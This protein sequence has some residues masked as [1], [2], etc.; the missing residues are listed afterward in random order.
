MDRN[1]NMHKLVNERMSGWS[2]LNAL[3]PCSS[4]L[5]KTWPPAPYEACVG[6]IST[7]L[8]HLNSRRVQTLSCTRCFCSLSTEG[9]S[10]PWL[11]SLEVGLLIPSGRCPA[12]LCWRS[13]CVQLWLSHCDHPVLPGGCPTHFLKLNITERKP[14]GKWPL[15][16]WHVESHGWTL[17]EIKCVQGIFKAAKE[18]SEL[19]KKSKTHA[20]YS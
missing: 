19:A 20:P 15:S 8:C 10:L 18:F 4:P 16:R 1:T 2:R 9:S 3:C 17:Q 7:N 6:W 12:C 5:I 14:T 11:L 13:Y